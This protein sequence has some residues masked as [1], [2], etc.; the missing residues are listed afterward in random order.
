VTLGLVGNAGHEE[1][2][3]SVGGHG[4]RVS[5]FGSR[6]TPQ[7]PGRE[8]PRSG[9]A[10]RL[11]ELPGSYCHLETRIIVLGSDRG[12]ESDRDIRQGPAGFL[13]SVLPHRL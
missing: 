4:D 9:L 1:A 12:M 2:K 3:V 8:K 6:E 13:Q 7:W 10:F 5:L 11:Q